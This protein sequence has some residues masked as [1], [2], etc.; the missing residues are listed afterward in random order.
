MA[1]QNDNSKKGIKI[2]DAFTLNHHMGITRE[3]SFVR[4][5]NHQQQVNIKA[6]RFRVER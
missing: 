6:Y 4:T 3:R 2:Q 5:P 1:D